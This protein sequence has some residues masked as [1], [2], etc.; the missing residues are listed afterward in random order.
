[1]KQAWSTSNLGND[2]GYDVRT[3]FA[4]AFSSGTYYTEELSIWD[5]VGR[6]SATEVIDLFEASKNSIILDWNGIAYEFD[7]VSGR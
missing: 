2:S 7:P 6:R 4:P 3:Y 1:M 5:V